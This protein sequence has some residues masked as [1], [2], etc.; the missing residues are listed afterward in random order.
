MG[1]HN[2]FEKEEIHI[3]RITVQDRMCKMSGSNYKP[4]G[5]GGDCCGLKLL[6]LGV[7]EMAEMSCAG[8]GHIVEPIENRRTLKTRKVRNEKGRWRN[9]RGLGIL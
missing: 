1:V 4:Y 6:K 3:K 7:T 5:V 2:L 9:P 8:R